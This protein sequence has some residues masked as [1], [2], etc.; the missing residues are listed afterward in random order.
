MRIP[1]LLS[2]AADGTLFSQ[3]FFIL[4]NSFHIIKTITCNINLFLRKRQEA[5]KY[6]KR[7]TFEVTNKEN[8]YATLGDPWQHLQQTGNEI[9]GNFGENKE[10][11]EAIFGLGVNAETK[12]WCVL[13]YLLIHILGIIKLF[14]LNTCQNKW[15][16]NKRFQINLFYVFSNA[17]CQCNSLIQM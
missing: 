15:R 5:L 3:L 14:I 12:N 9:P 11:Y 6:T 17:L 4:N 2:T 1:Q 13:L 7:G 16:N 8:M 10:L